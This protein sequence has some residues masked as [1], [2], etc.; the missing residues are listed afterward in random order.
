MGPSTAGLWLVGWF[1]TL[2]HDSCFFLFLEKPWY[3]RKSWPFLP[4]V[5]LICV[6][7]SWRSNDVND[8][9]QKWSAVKP[10]CLA[11]WWLFAVEKLVGCRSPF[12]SILDTPS[13]TCQKT[14]KAE[15]KY[16]SFT[17]KSEASLHPRFFHGKFHRENKHESTGEHHG[18]L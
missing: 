8:V 15:E 11:F 13:Q 18:F 7:C 6:D 10:E 3:C 1:L 4:L 12:G 16:I 17:R 5:G 14:C 9:F 2:F